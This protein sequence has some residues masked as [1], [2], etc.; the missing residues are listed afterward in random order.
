MIAGGGGFLGLNIARSLAKKGQKVLL[1]QRRAVARHPLLS[2][3][4]DRQVKQAAGNVLNWPFLSSLV[5][6]YATDSIVHGAFG[7][8]AI[9]NPEIMKSG[10][11][12]LVQVELEG[13]RNLLELTR[14][15]GLRRLTFISSVDCYRGWPSECTPSGNP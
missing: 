7:T 15:A 8:A 14:I 5:Q 11:P 9:I 2:P 1:V 6:Q 4:W 12:R 13:S 3:Y 10:L